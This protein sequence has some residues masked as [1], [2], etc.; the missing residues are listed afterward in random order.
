MRYRSETH[1][2][3]MFA[4]SAIDGIHQEF[5]LRVTFDTEFNPEIRSHPVGERT[6][7]TA[8]SHSVAMRWREDANAAHRLHKDAVRS[9]HKQV[10]P[11]SR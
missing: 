2:G 11:R 6:L 8:P 5:T 3:E 10:L 9:T 7:A 4:R 1:Q